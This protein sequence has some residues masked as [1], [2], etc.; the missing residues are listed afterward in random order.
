M[1]DPHT[2]TLL[3]FKPQDR[4]LGRHV[5]H[6]AR[7]LRF[8][9]PAKDPRKLQSRR[10]AVNSPIL[11]QGN[12]GACT[13]YSLV[14][15]LA[16]G[17]FWSAGKKVLSPTDALVNGAVAL[18]FYSEATRLDPWEGVYE[19]DDTGSDGLSAAKAAHAHGLIS[20]YQH[21]TSL[22]AA[23]TGLAE[24][25]VMFGIGW[26]SGMYEPDSDGRIRITGDVE[27]GHEITADEIDVERERIWFRQ[28]WGPGYGL[29]GRG[30]VTWDDAG[31]LL[32]DYG[33]CTILVPKSEPAPV[34]TPEPEPKP[35]EP[36]GPRPLD[37][38]LAEGLRKL[39]DN[40]DVPKYIRVPAE[41]WLANF[42]KEQS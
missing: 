28:T 11:D 16:S 12:V 19:P 1:A 42:S 38:P 36:T 25:C 17:V 4:R 33:D 29:N 23:L 5:N 31:I 8:R 27:G 2:L 40:R 6:D 24:R 35:V 41:P 20:G 7:S 3:E 15:V 14:N 18:N 10:H 22:A 13:G 37:A 34:P 32:A 30:W 9:A 26:R 39:L 21:A